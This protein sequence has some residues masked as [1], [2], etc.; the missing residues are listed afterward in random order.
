MKFLHLIPL[1]G[2]TSA[3]YCPAERG[4]NGQAPCEPSTKGE[5]VNVEAEISALREQVEQ[6]ERT[7]AE[8]D[9]AIT[10]LLTSLIEVAEESSLASTLDEK[11]IAVGGFGQDLIE[12]MLESALTRRFALSAANLPAA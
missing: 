4:A 3:W 1:L 10:V 6:L 11:S 9:A 7:C 5:T 12:R 2:D 8:R